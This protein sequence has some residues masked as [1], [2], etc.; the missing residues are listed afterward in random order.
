MLGWARQGTDAIV[1]LYA[2]DATMLD[3]ELTCRVAQIEQYGHR[4]IH[5]IA[6]ATL[7]EK[8]DQPIREPFGFIDGYSQ[9]I[10]RG[11]PRWADQHSQNQVIEAGEIILGYPDNLGYCPPCRRRNGFSIGRNGT[12]LV[13]RQLEQDPERFCQ[14][15]DQAAKVIAADP[16][17]PNHDPAS[18]REWIAAKMVGRWRKDGTSLVRHP[19]PPGTPAASPSRRTMTFCSAQKTRTVYG[20]HSER[21]FAA[22]NPRDSLEPGSQ[23]QIAITNRH[24]ILR[25]GRPYNGKDNRWKNPGPAIHVYEYRYRRAIRVSAADLG[26]WAR[27]PW[28]GK[29][30]RSNR[31]PASGCL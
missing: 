7:P 11:T 16:R 17:S 1:L 31:R 20:V 21:I 29:R 25:V 27:L 19:T 3:K 18:V 28:I 14:Y 26:A 24:R 6:L 23:K 13:V 30:R 5:E 10:I 4:K 2:K 15:L 8:D 12:F 22:P 9:P